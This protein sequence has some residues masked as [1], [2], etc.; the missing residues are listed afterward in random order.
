MALGIAPT[1]RLKTGR[2]FRRPIRPIW[3][4]SHRWEAT[5]CFTPRWQ[6]SA[7]LG[8]EPNIKVEDGIPETVRWLMD[9]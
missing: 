8:Y 5:A 3:I 1:R 9:Q 4:D 7:E 2:L 6:G